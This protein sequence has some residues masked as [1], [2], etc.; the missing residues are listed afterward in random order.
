[1][2]QKHEISKTFFVFDRKRN[3]KTKS[4]K[5]GLYRPFLNR[6]SVKIFETNQKNSKR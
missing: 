4:R 6:V 2:V 1:M 3:I 5:N